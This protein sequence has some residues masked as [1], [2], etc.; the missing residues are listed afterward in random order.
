MAVPR[1]RY[2]TL[3]TTTKHSRLF[4]K[5]TDAHRR[6][7]TLATN[8]AVNGIT[9]TQKRPAAI[10]SPPLTTTNALYTNNNNTSSTANGSRQRSNTN[11]EDTAVSTVNNNRRGSSKVCCV[12]CKPGDSDE[13]NAPPIFALTG[14]GAISPKY[15]QRHA[16][17]MPAH[18]ICTNKN[19]TSDFQRHADIFDSARAGKSMSANKHN[20][21][22]ISG[23]AICVA[24]DNKATISQVVFSRSQPF[25]VSSNNTNSKAS[26]GPS[27]PLKD[28]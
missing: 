8:T 17:N 4:L 14:C 12:Y 23:R 24:N 20:T 10:Q 2:R 19:C 15:H 16:I 5:I 21:S 13:N 9:G 27:I 26:N 18:K 25:R 28:Q 22:G 6:C 3:P 7:N 1:H 11:S